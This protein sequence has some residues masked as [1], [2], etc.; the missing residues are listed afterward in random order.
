MYSDL[1][2]LLQVQVK[3]ERDAVEER[4]QRGDVGRA[5]VPQGEAEPRRLS[6]ARDDDDDDDDDRGRRC[7]Q[8]ETKHLEGLPD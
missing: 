3:L 1:D 8:A 4:R 7:E 6:T 2:I 5:V